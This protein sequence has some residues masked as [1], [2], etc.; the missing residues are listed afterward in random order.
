ML[1]ELVAQP[2]CIHVYFSCK[3]AIKYVYTIHKYGRGPVDIWCQ[4]LPLYG[5][6]SVELIATAF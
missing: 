6:Q 2:H 3:V 5:C 4:I 1:R